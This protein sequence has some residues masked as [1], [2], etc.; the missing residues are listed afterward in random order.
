M[1]YRISVEIF[2]P[3][4]PPAT[5]S[6]VARLVSDKVVDAAVVPEDYAVEQFRLAWRT[7][8]RALAEGAEG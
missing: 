4:D 1:Q 2:D 7:L 8:R 3:A 5:R 6:S